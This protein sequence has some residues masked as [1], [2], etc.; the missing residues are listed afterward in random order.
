[1]WIWHLGNCL[2]L[3]GFWNFF[4]FFRFFPSKLVYFWTK[5]RKKRYGC[6]F[7]SICATDLNFGNKNIGRTKLSTLKMLIFANFW[8]VFIKKILAPNLLIYMYLHY[9]RSSSWC[10]TML[11]TLINGQLHLHLAKPRL[12]LLYFSWLHKK[13]R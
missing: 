4:V 9:V 13:A 6:F 5:S 10:A 7:H 12:P 8:V 11:D 1:M 2:E 3:L